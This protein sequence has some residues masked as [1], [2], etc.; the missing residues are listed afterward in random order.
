MITR[1]KKA[2][3]NSTKMISLG[4]NYENTHLINKNES[5]QSHLKNQYKEENYNLKN[6]E[7]F[8]IK[9]KTLRTKFL[10]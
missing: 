8:R 1:L 4:N 9:I 2:I 7:N 3:L 6:F 10:K 5:N